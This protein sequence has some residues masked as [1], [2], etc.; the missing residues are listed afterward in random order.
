[1]EG[2][3]MLALWFLHIQIAELQQQPGDLSHQDDSTGV[4]LESTSC[5][6]LSA[7]LLYTCHS[8]GIIFNTC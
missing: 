3:L 7:F 6:Y 2:T 8:C 4:F 5:Y 1:M